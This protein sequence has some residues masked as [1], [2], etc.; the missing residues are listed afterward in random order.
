M[1]A[2][3]YDLHVHELP[4]NDTRCATGE[5]DLVQNADES[6]GLTP[7]IKEMPTYG[8]C[9]PGEYVDYALPLTVDHDIDENIRVQINLRGNEVRPEALT[10][11]SRP[12]TPSL[13]PSHT[14]SHGLPP[15]HT[16]AHPCSPLLTLTR[17][18]ACSHACSPLLTSAHSH[19]VSRHPATIP[20]VRPEAI[21]LLVYNRGEIPTDRKSEV[22][23]DMA[24]DGIFSLTVNLIDLKYQLCTAVNNNHTLCAHGGGH[25]STNTSDSSAG[26]SG[27]HRRLAEALPD[28]NGRRLS[29]APAATG[30][31]AVDLMYYI[32]VKCSDAAPASYQLLVTAIPS[33]LV[34]GVSVHGEL[35]PGAMVYYHWEHAY[36]GEQRSVPPSRRNHLAASCHARFH[37]HPL[38]PSLGATSPPPPPAADSFAMRA[39]RVG[40]LPHHEARRRRGSD[41]PPR[42]VHR[43]SSSQALAALC[44][45]GPL[46]P[47]R[48]RR[49]L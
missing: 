31:A 26:S 24:V 9:L 18:P 44:P 41:G 22:Y 21:K 16:P 6:T 20:Q 25:G 33:H 11:F 46:R 34:T 7:L 28:T 5:Y 10:L 43:R 12:L 32:S 13:A 1:Y 30:G 40:A 29:A 39:L 3:R 36:I 35:C 23:T 47:P 38:P 27:G 45:P 17:S 48:V 8:S 42:L 4:Q 37:H 19:T 14:V 15:A 2:C 49:V